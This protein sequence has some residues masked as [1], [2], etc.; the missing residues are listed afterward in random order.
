MKKL[1][2]FFSAMLLMTMVYS[3]KSNVDLAYKLLTED[4][5]Y[6]KAVEVIEKACRHSDTKN[7][8]LTWFIASYSYGN[9]ILFEPFNKTHIDRTL[10]C[11]RTGR[12]LDNDGE[13]FSSNSP[14][15]FHLIGTA[16]FI[17]AVR[18]GNENHYERAD[19]FYNR[20]IEYHRAGKDDVGILKDSWSAHINCINKY[21]SLESVDAETGFGILNDCY[22]HL[23]KCDEL[24]R[25]FSDKTPEEMGLPFDYDDFDSAFY[26]LGAL[27]YNGADKLYEQG[28]Y[29]TAKEWLNSAWAC[30]SMYDIEGNEMKN[31]KEAIAYC[32]EAIRTGKKA[33]SSTPQPNKETANDIGQTRKG[34][35]VD[36]DIPV[37]NATADNTYAFIIANENYD[38]REVPY[39]LNDGRIFKEYCNKTLGIPSN[40]IKIYENASGN[41]IIA[42]VAAIRRASEAND[43]DLN[44]IFYYAGHAFPDE[45]TKDAYLLPVDG[46]NQLVETCYSLKRL[47]QELGSIKTKSCVCFL[48]ACFSGA[49]REDNMLLTGRGV[50]I[51]P[52]EE[53]PQGNLIVFTSASGNETAHQYEEKQHGLFTYYLLKK[54]Q[55]SKG[56]FTLGE[57]YDY[58]SKNVKKTSYDV[59]NKIQTPSVIPSDT[60]GTKWRN[61]KL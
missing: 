32:D 54:M 31:I 4:N 51:K 38:N 53:T 49:T 22:E 42:C 35:G 12:S 3:Q 18:L 45:R 7:D 33:P 16:Y 17:E 58:V 1:T 59:N 40:H 23:M 55:D 26:H 6:A 15:P 52:K 36:V 2:S 43:G 5:N 30:V 29:E 44:V 48:D 56:T 19:Y 25:L 50:A 27:Y 20:A 61:I 21:Y 14:G 46:D 47:Y 41:K 9:L 10:E 60:M 57:M 24:L 39:A 8:P 11:I 34:T 13:C 37:S 28:Y